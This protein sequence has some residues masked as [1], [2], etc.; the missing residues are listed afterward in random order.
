[1]SA[2]PLGSTIKTE[3]IIN[4]PS[5]YKE[6]EGT[7]TEGLSN[8]LDQICAD[9]SASW[10]TWQSNVI[11]SGD[12][13]TGAGIGT[14]TGTG[15]GGNF[16]INMSLSISDNF[17][18]YQIMPLLTELVDAISIGWQTKFNAWKDSYSF[19][20][21]VVWTGTSTATSVSAGIFNATATELLI[22][23]GVS[24]TNVNTEISNNM[25]SFDFINGQVEDLINAIGTSLET[26]WTSWATNSS[27]SPSVTGVASAG[28]GAGTGVS[29]LGGVS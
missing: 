3:I 21:S 27:V 20:S 17:G 5:T 14:W 19:L 11:Y 1:M 10:A 15:G 16:D 8:F 7:I 25:P 2:V 29:V 26:L 18:Q 4:L 6:L 23:H 28:S 9:I 13:V 22:T 24:P 12:T